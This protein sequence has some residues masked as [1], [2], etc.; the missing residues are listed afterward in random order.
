MG[1]FLYHFDADAIVEVVDVVVVVVALDVV[2]S[3]E[4]IVVVDAS[5]VIGGL[6]EKVVE[7]CGSNDSAD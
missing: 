4:E 2:V 7:R 5:V 1:S 6:L 3:W